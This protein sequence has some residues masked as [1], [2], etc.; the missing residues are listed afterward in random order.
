ME[1]NLL[2]GNSAVTMRSPLGVKGARD[3]VFRHNTVVGDLPANATRINREGDNPAIETVRF[4]HNVFSDTAGT[5]TDFS[6]TLPADLSTVRPSTLL[7]N[8]Y[9]NAGVALPFDPDD[10]LNIS[11]DAGRLDGDP[12]LPS[13][14]AAITPYWIPASDQF[15]GGHASIRAAFEAI[16]LQYGV[17]AAGSVVPDATN[18][19]AE[20]PPTDLLGRPRNPAAADLGAVEVSNALLVN[21]FEPL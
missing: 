4:V 7:R 21:G 1:N 12:R 5:M 9:Y 18:Q 15:N 13:P 20:W 2:L 17:P 14:A 3:I 10:V 19:P 6:D 11:G 8:A 16:A